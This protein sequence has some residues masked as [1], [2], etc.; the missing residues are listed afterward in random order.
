M[1]CYQT[2]LRPT[3]LPALPSLNFSAG[4]EYPTS[5]GRPA[6][7]GRKPRILPRFP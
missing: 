1:R 3:I 6:R 5:K 7:A 4:I 2:R